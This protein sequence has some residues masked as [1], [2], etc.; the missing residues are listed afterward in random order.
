[1]LQHHKKAKHANLS[2]GNNVHYY[3]SNHIY[4][5]IKSRKR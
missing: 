1:M 2:I 5:F 3:A 4:K